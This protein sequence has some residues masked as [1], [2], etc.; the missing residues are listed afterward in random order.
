MCWNSSDW[1]SVETS[2]AR[3]RRPIETGHVVIRLVVRIEK[4]WQGET[5]T[6]PSGHSDRDRSRYMLENV[7]IILSQHHITGLLCVQ[8]NA[9]CIHVY[10][11]TKLF[12]FFSLY[13]VLSSFFSKNKTNVSIFKIVLRQWW[14]KYV[15]NFLFTKLKHSFTYA[16]FLFFFLNHFSRWIESPVFVLLLFFLSAMSFD[17]DRTIWRFYFSFWRGRVLYYKY[18]IWD[19][20]VIGCKVSFF[21]T[22]YLLLL[23]QHRTSI[24]LC[25]SHLFFFWGG[26]VMNFFFFFSFSNPFFQTQHTHTTGVSFV[27]K[28]NYV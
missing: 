25:T 28:P 10:L 13:F 14:P 19:K 12:I 26:I 16:P 21:F 24:W 20:I 3:F 11:R 2:T 23:K 6:Y 15:Y 9:R 4:K 27:C 22:F 5:E 17:C 8:R 7:L 1:R 18:C